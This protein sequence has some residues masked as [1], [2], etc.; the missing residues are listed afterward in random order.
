M[1]HLWRQSFFVKMSSL[2][3][4]IK[5]FNIIWYFSLLI[6]IFILGLIFFC[7]KGLIV[8]CNLLRSHKH[9]NYI[10][11]LSCLLYCNSLSFIVP[12]CFSAKFILPRVNLLLWCSQIFKSWSFF[13]S[14]V[15][16]SCEMDKSLYLWGGGDECLP[17]PQ[18]KLYVY[19]L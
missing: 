3:F 4:L 18:K 15:R 6:L 8:N 5:I 2:S 16:F 19:T 17:R 13:Y 1:F 10:W 9:L 11:G 12:S 14:S 7:L